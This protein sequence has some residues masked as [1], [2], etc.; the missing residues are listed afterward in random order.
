MITLVRTFAGVQPLV[1][2]VGHVQCKLLATVAAFVRFFSRVR[3]HVSPQSLLA[4]EPQ[5]A[6]RAHKLLLGCVHLH[7]AVVI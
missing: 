7:V 6:L 1:H 5:R 4:Q 3:Q 2:L